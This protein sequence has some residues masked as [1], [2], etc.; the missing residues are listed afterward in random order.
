MVNNKI[1]FGW[2]DFLFLFGI[3]FLAAFAVFCLIPASSGSI[4]NVPHFIG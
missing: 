2:D 4:L 3:F 1:D